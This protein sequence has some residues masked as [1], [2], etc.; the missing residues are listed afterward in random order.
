MTNDNVTIL[1][2]GNDNGIKFAAKGNGT[3]IGT[4]LTNINNATPTGSNITLS[5]DGSATFNSTIQSGEYAAGAAGSIQIFNNTASAQAFKV[6]NTTNGSNIVMKS[7]GTATFGAFNQSSTSGNGTIISHD[8]QVTVQRPSGSSSYLFRGFQGTTEKYFVKADG[9]AEFA[10]GNINLYSNGSAIFAAGATFGNDVNTSTQFTIENSGVEKFRVNS[11]GSCFIGNPANSGNTSSTNRRVLISAVD[12]SAS[13]AGNGEFNRSVALKN[14]YGADTD[15][16]AALYTRNAADDSTTFM[17]NYDGSAT[18]AGGAIELKSSGQVY[19]NR[20]VG[21]GACFY[22]NLNGSNTSSILA[23]GSADFVAGKF[24]ARNVSGAGVLE[25]QTSA[26]TQ[27]VLIDGRDGS[28][29]FSGQLQIGGGESATYGYGGIFYSNGGSTSNLSTVY[30]RNMNSGGRVWAGDN[31]VGATTS[32]IYGNGSASFNSHITVNGGVNS[33]STTNYGS[34]RY[35]GGEYYAQTASATSSTTDMIRI[36]YGTSVTTRIRANGEAKFDGT[37][38]VGSFNTGSNGT[39]GADLVKGLVQVQQPTANSSN[40]GLWAGYHGVTQTSVIRAGGN[41]FFSGNITAGN[42]SD[43]KFKENITDANPQLSD[44]VALG[45]ILKNWDWKEEAPLNEELRA[46]RFL[47]LVA[48]EAE[49]IC[50]G[51]VYDVHRKVKGEELT[52]ETTDEDGNVTPATYE[53]VDDSYK[54]INHD[55]LVMKL[56]GAIAELEAKVAALEAG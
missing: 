46:K 18:F 56:L 37:V 36:Y 42:V 34:V 15:N 2:A 6:G 21:T 13:F 25:L 30:A 28:A 43:I 50:P 9:S 1:Y 29:T 53:E 8:G 31:S 12:G 27:K 14:G 24:R 39:Q 45:G 55:I 38:S 47:G 40:N 33:G 41:A 52:P 5:T 19:S 22:G 3:Y 44:V 26:G 10:G 4:S 54:A 16:Y 20:T 17:V 35:G 48:Q 11:D 51:I 49:E 32:Q 23:D 7:D